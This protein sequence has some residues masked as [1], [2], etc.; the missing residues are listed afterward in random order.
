MSDPAHDP[1]CDGLPNLS[2]AELRASKLSALDVG[3]IVGATLTGGTTLPFLITHAGD[4]QLNVRAMTS[5]F[6]LT[7]DREKGE[8]TEIDDGHE[9]LWRIVSMQPLPLEYHHLMLALDRRMRLGSNGETNPLDEGDRRALL[10]LEG[11][12]AAHPI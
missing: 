6:P 4:T 7:F 8:A 9:R 2:P 5:Q 11:H 10:N 3:D 12:W 1:R